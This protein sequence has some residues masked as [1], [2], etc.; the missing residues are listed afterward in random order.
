M[1]KT[2]KEKYECDASKTETV[3]LGWGFWAGWPKER[4]M[5]RGEWNKEHM[6]ELDI[7]ILS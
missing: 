4:R 5:G 2:I 7:K 1:I 3:H 6:Q